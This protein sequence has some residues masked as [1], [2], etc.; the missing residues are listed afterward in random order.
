M[1]LGIFLP[2]RVEFLAG[3]DPVALQSIGAATP[4][5][6]EKQPSP[7]KEV[8]TIKNLNQRA[9]YVEIRAANLKKIPSWHKAAGQKAWLFVDELLVNPEASKPKDA[10]PKPVVSL[11]LIPPSP[12]TDQITLDVRA[13]VWNDGPTTRQFAV[14]VYLDDE[15]PGNRLHQQFL[16]GQAKREP[17]P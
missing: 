3:N 5:A 7:L 16:A 4:V 17:Q 2:R 14:A 9:R 1:P 10:A 8:F 15:N 13:A 11:T 6:T 12:V